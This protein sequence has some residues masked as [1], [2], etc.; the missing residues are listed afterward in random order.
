[1]G[2]T[3]NPDGSVSIDMDTIK[4][5]AAEQQRGFRADAIAAMDG[6]SLAGVGDISKA[7]NLIND[8]EIWKCH[9]RINAAA[10]TLEDEIQ[11]TRDRLDDA[12]VTA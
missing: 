12:E 9:K 7:L 11:N 4:N 3:F 6:F 2:I 1:M 8:P 5:I 10:K